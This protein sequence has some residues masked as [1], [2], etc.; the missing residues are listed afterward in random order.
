MTI[1]LTDEEKQGQPISGSKLELA[2]AL[3]HTRGY[4]V[5]ENVFQPERLRQLN[6]AVTSARQDNQAFDHRLNLPVASPFV[7]DDIVTNP[8]ILG[9]ID[10]VI[11]ADCVLRMI[12]ADTNTA[13]AEVAEEL[14]IESKPLFPETEHVRVPAHKLH[15]TIPYADL[16]ETN[17]ALEVWSASH[18]QPEHFAKKYSAEI[19]EILAQASPSIRINVPAGAVLIRD[20]KLWH[21]EH[22]NESGE[23]L[24][25]LSLTYQ[26][27]WDITS[28]RLVI[29]DTVYQGASQ[30]LKKLLR[31]ESLPVGKKTEP[32]Y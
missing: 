17:G 7:D 3:L 24:T 29:L 26:R 27:W 4:L 11:G 13:D 2:A 19:I 1:R 31:F 23:S 18:A 8:L 20:S 21:R 6:D 12:A 5:V 22:P 28:P 25:A 10:Q 14:Q 32:S 16:N 9:V 30:R 15:I